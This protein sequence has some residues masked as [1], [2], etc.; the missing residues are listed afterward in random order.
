MDRK[1]YDDRQKLEA[2]S[3]RYAHSFSYHLQERSACYRRKARKFFPRNKTDYQLW[4]TAMGPDYDS[5][6]PFPL[7]IV[8][9]RNKCS[10][11]FT[12]SHSSHGHW[13]LSS[14]F[15]AFR[16]L[17]T[18]YYLTFTTMPA[19]YVPPNRPR[20]VHH[21]SVPFADIIFLQ[22]T[23]FTETEKGTQPLTQLSF[24]IMHTETLRFC[25]LRHA[26]TCNLILFAQLKTVWSLERSVDVDPK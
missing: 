20:H 25:Q 7:S 11:T 10:F 16:L 13:Q 18:I 26:K 14:S 19:K 6:L 3:T 8:I 9:F 1:T 2:I 24:V 22:I 21:Y 12:H 15:S 17:C 5:S 4:V 23:A